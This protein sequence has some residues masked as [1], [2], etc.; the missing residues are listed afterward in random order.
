MHPDP[1]H[2]AVLS[3]ESNPIQAARSNEVQKTFQTNTTMGFINTRHK[4]K[5]QLQIF[6]VES[7]KTVFKIKVQSIEYCDEVMYPFVAV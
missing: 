4:L 2:R 7:Q 5:T 6:Q 1:L 3:Q